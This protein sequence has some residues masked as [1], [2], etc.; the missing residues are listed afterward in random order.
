ME[1]QR[2]SN[3][4]LLRI[5]LMIAI[6]LYHLMVYGGVIYL[7]Y[8]E[9]TLPGLIICSGSA[10]VA[11][12]AFMALSS[13]FLLDS[14]G[15]PILSRLLRIFFQVLLMYIV[16]RVIVCE[17]LGYSQDITFYNDFFIKGSWWFIYAYFLILI[18][19]PVLN[20][21][22]YQ[23]DISKL[24]LVCGLLG[25]WFLINGFTNDV[26]MLND[27]LGFIF[28]YFV[29]G[30]LKRTDFKSFLGIPIKKSNMIVI[31]CVGYCITLA[32]CYYL[33][34]FGPV[35]DEL[36]N[37][38]IQHLVGKYAFIQFVMGISVF[39]IFRSIQIPVTK[40]INNLAQNVFYVFLLHETVLAVFW[41]FGKLRTYDNQLPF[42]N[43]VEFVGSCIIYIVSSFFFASIIRFL[44][45]V[46]FA[47][48]VEKSITIIYKISFVKR[49]EEKYLEVTEWRA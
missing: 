10:I 29:I 25:A 45:Q 4:E 1:K 21:I 34:A 2:Q 11:D 36:A 26:N 33:K 32:I 16:K 8:N 38:M 43:G 5:I 17:I 47:R 35:G 13:Y 48:I 49:I 24:R 18:I 28:I 27:I 44:Y 39:L 41:Y 12:Y 20:K 46:F 14:Q 40:W 37:E 30:Y 19:Y 42:T 7:P 23:L 9:F 31:F 6:P 3:Y 22:I 15:C